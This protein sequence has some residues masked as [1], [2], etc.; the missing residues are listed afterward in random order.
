MWAIDTLVEVSYLAG[1]ATYF[2]GL[3]YCILVLTHSA[4]DWRMKYKLYIQCPQIIILSFGFDILRNNNNSVNLR[5]GLPN[6]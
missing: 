1:F 2:A 4:F 5:I 3:P 6:S